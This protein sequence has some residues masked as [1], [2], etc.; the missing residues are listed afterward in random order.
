MEPSPRTHPLERAHSKKL[1]NHTAALGALPSPGRVLLPREGAGWRAS[2]DTPS[3]FPV[4][5]PAACRP[6]SIFSDHGEDTR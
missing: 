4:A 1:R 3:P 2:L 6:L 5:C